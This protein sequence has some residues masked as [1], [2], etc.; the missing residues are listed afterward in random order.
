MAQEGN[1]V[2]IE[3]AKNQNRRSFA[4]KTY[5]ELDQRNQ[6]FVDLFVECNTQG[7]AYA[8]ATLWRKA[9]F[10]SEDDKLASKYASTKIKELWHIIQKRL[11]LRVRRKQ[12]VYLIRM[13]KLSE[14]SNSPAI[15]FNATKE[16]LKYGHVFD[17]EDAGDDNNKLTEKELEEKL[18][19]LMEKALDKRKDASS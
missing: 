17:D 14:Q 16:L 4:D 11:N 7:K 2:E 13:E 6:D 8:N 15:A 5:E 9:G 1:V 10:E 18:V 12:P 19:S 3:S